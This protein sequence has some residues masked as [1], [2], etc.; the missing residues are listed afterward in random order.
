MGKFTGGC[1]CGAV[2]YEVNADPVLAGHCQ[3]GKCQKLS[4]G[5]HGS[6][7]AFPEPT[8]KLTGQLSFWSYTADSGHEAKRGF[9]PN[10]GT[11]VMGKPSSVP[12]IAA[13]NLGSLDDA[14]AIEPKM[15]FYTARGQPWDHMAS[16]LMAFP[17]M[18]PM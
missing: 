16:D 6:F 17:G 2:R 9:C 7:A 12:G 11:P 3:C 4:G 1:A 8:V 10:C 14:S 15:V 5:G 13:I 18:P